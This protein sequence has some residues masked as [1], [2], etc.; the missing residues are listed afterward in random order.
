MD[1]EDK[2]LSLV[3]VGCTVDEKL[4]ELLSLQFDEEACNN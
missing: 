3:S 1:E 4:V 2:L